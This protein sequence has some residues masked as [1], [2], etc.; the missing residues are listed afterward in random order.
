M[1]SLS[2]GQRVRLRV[3]KDRAFPVE[4]SYDGRTGRV[5]NLTGNPWFPVQV[6][7]DPGKSARSIAYFKESE[8]EPIGEG[9][10]V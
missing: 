7:V 4:A 3:K 9:D 5:V 10:D 1:T 8:C 2:I 6:S